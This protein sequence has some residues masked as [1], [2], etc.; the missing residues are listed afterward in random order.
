MSGYMAVLWLFYVFCTMHSIIMLRLLNTRKN[1]NR[2]NPV[3]LLA[4]FNSCSRDGSVG[5]V[6]R[7]WAEPTGRRDVRLTI[8][9]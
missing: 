8:H 7:I 1:K 9:T 2:M 4:Y 3:N 5:T 6:S